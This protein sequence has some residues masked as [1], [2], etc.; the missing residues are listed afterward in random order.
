MHWT[1]ALA[2]MIASSVGVVFSLIA[3]WRSSAA[4]K[5]TSF[6]L[7]ELQETQRI[8]QESPTDYNDIFDIHLLRPMTRAANPHGHEDHLRRMD[9]HISTPAYGYH[10]LGY[11]QHSEF[12][13]LLDAL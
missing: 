10:V 8:V 9:L 7:K 11:D 12:R 5:K 13:R 2:G 1:F 4:D 6:L 3:A